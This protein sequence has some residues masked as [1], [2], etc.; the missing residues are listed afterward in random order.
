VYRNEPQQW[1]TI[2]WPGK[3]HGAKLK[4]KGAGGLSEEINRP[5]DFGFFHL[6]DAAELKGFGGSKTMIATWQLKSTGTAPVVKIDI[7]P[8]RTENPFDPTF[9]LNYDC[10]R[11]MTGR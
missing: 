7:R 10:P 2:T 8:Q 6:L 11:S 1:T 3:S 4:V 5:G 9:F